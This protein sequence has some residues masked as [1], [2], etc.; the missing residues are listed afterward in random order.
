MF[1]ESVSIL[2]LDFF[3][4]KSKFGALLP[5]LTKNT[6]RKFN[7]TPT[8]PRVTKEYK[9]HKLSNTVSFVLHYN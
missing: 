4:P 6:K 5:S 3:F 1:F 2:W 9:T 8:E 7:Q